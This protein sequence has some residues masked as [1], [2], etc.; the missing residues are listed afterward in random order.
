[1]AK[2]QHSMLFNQETR[3][4]LAYFLSLL[5]RL[6]P[7]G[8][9][10][11]LMFGGTSEDNSL[12][13]STFSRKSISSNQVKVSTSSK[14]LLF[15]EPSLWKKQ[16]SEISFKQFGLNQQGRKSSEVSRLNLSKSP[17]SCLTKNCTEKNLQW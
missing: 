8:Y 16:L 7:L 4:F 9:C 6:R 11:P 2:R 5:Q 15:L 17:F 1:M 3:V 12:T 13:L 14:R 10:A